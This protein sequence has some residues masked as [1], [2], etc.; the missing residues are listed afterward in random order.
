MLLMATVVEVEAWLFIV[1]VALIVLLRMVTGHID[2][3]GAGFHRL[4]LLIATLGVGV[5]YVSLVAANHDP[6]TLPD[7][8]TPAA[9]G[10]GGSGLA[11]LGT[12]LVKFWPAIT[13]RG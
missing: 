5:Y 11:Y 3:G 10:F 2:L 6:T 1:A 7:P 9:I 13:N 4:Q 8:G 12:K